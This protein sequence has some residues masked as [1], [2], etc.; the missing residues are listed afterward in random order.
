MCTRARRL[1]KRDEESHDR[2]VHAGAVTAPVCARTSS[3]LNSP[4]L[5]F[6]VPTVASGRCA[7]T[8]T[9]AGTIKAWKGRI[10]RRLQI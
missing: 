3:I 8:A 7:D 2:I 9:T 6:T 10:A 4:V 1:G 5:L